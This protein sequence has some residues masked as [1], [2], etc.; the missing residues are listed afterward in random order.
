MFPGT[1]PDNTQHSLALLG[2]SKILD[3]AYLA[4]ESSLAL[5]LGHRRSIDFDFFSKAEFNVDEIKKQL[6]KIGSHEVDNES[7]KTMVGKFNEIKFS[8]FYY[9]YPLIKPTKKFLNINLASL[10]D[11]AG[12]K[13]VAITDRGTRKDFI[14][15]YFLAKKCFPFEKM[16]GFYDKKYQKLSSNLFT[17]IKSLQFYYDADNK[18]MP[19]MIEKV[20][21]EEVKK[22]MQ[23]EV[24]RLANK[25][26]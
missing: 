26:I 9:P 23:K 2:K 13:L 3:Q 7:P 1:L 4:G 17:L 18:E 25:Y 8:Y 5:Q 12:M 16:F 15:L 14:D 21:W 19:E 24:V 22:F 10:E 20:E 6:N 11:I